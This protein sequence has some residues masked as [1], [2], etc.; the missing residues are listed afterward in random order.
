MK[1][2]LEKDKK[3]RKKNYHFDKKKFIL[4][5]ISQN[6]NFFNLI[7]WKSNTNLYKLPIQSSKT[8]ITNRCIKTVNKKKFNKLTNFS[9]MIFIKLMKLKQLNNTYKGS[10]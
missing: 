6:L 2:L 10:W 1:K 5:Y 3:I 8:F 9:R 7:R 4:K